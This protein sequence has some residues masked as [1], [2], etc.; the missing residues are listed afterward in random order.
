[1]SNQSSNV[2]VDVDL[3]ALQTWK[4]KMQ[5]LGDTTEQALAKYE[6][7]IKKL[8]ECWVGNAAEGFKKI[9]NDLVTFARNYHNS[10]K[11]VEELLTTVSNTVSNQ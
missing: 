7:D 4:E 1:M 10:M 2:Q 3:D 6:S 11:D 5:S 8:D 9:N